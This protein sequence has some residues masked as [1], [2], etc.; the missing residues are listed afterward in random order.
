MFTSIRVVCNNTLHIATR[1]K[2]GIR[3]THNRRFDAEKVKEEL[4]IDKWQIFAD[5][6]KRL[7]ERKVSDDECR[8]FVAECIAAGNPHKDS[9][10]YLDKNEE[11]PAFKQL[12]TNINTAP[13]QDTNAAKGTAYGLLQG[14]TYY[15]NHEI[16]SKSNDIRTDSVLFGRGNKINQFGMQKALELV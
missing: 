14:L 1:D 6:C 4:G 2:S 9:D 15:T 12:L 5:N 16:P 11:N 3:I 10:Y 7:S 13:G 8:K